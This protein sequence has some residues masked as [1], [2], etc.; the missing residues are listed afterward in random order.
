MNVESARIVARNLYAKYAGCT[1]RD[2]ERVLRDL[3]DSWCMSLAEATPE[4]AEEVV[5]KSI[6][7]FAEKVVSANAREPSKEAEQGTRL[8]P[9]RTTLVGVIGD[10]AVDDNWRP[11][12]AEAATDVVPPEFVEE[13]EYEIDGEAE[14]GLDP[15]ERLGGTD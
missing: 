11:V 5:T 6:V 2:A 7:R 13:E 12:P 4:E 10:P 14:S 1:R 9:A 8:R 15:D 3:D